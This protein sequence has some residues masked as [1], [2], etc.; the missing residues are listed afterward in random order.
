MANQGNNCMPHHLLKLTVPMKLGQ[1]KW[2]DGVRSSVSCSLSGIG[3]PLKQRPVYLFQS[4][5]SCRINLL[6]NGKISGTPNTSDFLKS[7]KLSK[8]TKGD[9][10]W[11]VILLLKISGRETPPQLRRIKGYQDDIR[12]QSFLLTAAWEQREMGEMVVSPEL[13][14]LGHLKP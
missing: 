2:R 11:T 9:T 4:Q 5:V 6:H 7:H 3:Q 8:L 10:R 12:N 14:R 13:R 1:Q